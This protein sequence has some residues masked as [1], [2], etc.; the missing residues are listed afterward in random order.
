MIKTLEE[1]KGYL[2]AG[3]E[4]YSNQGSPYIKDSKG[5]NIPVG[6]NTYLE[7]IKLM[8]TFM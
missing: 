1:L 5:L 8:K 3:A 4:L 7:Y 6:I 2:S